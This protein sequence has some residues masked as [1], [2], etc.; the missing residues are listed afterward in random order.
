MKS[1]SFDSKSFPPRL[2][3]A[4]LSVAFAC[5]TLC[6]SA[7]AG[8]TVALT[9]RYPSEG[10]HIAAVPA[11]YTFGAAE[12]G[13][14]V[15]VN[16]HAAWI[17]PD[18]GWS[19][20]VP[21]QPGRFVLHVTARAGDAVQQVDRSIVVD[22]GE[23]SPFPSG[24]TIVQPLESVALQLTAAAGSAV[25]ASSAA[26]DTIALSPDPALGAGAYS[27]R[28]IARGQA[29]TP[30]RVTY[31]VVDAAGLERTLRSA[32]TIA[33]AS[34]PVLFAGVVVGFTPDPLSGTRPYA[35]LGPTPDAATDIMLPVGTEVNVT[36]RFGDRLRLAL[37]GQPPEFVDTHQIAPLRGVRAIPP[38]RLQSLDRAEDAQATTFRLTFA[39]TRPAFHVRELGGASGTIRVFGVGS[40]T[41]YADYPF[42]LR[43]HAFWGYRASWHGSTLVVVF[44]KPPAFAPPPHKALDGLRVVIDPGHSPDAGAIG[45]LGTEE[46]DVNLDIALRLAE[47]LRAVGARVTLTRTSNAAVLLY[48]RPALAER[49]GA[50]V[51][52][53]VHNNANPDGVDPSG[54]HGYEVY[55]FQPHSAALAQAI[56]AA[57]QRDVDI[58]DNG[59]H[60]GDFALVRTTDVPAVLTESAYVTWPWEEMR[61]RDPA[62]RARLAGAMADGM[63]RW[64]ERMRRLETDM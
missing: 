37:P 21:M 26:F 28:A 17:A 16:G 30:D 39:G 10:A 36:G 33:V 4:A 49:L 1:P 24:P 59:L 40:D 47:R 8:T 11:S 42:R 7:R 15:T 41:R 45:P 54:A 46:R 62:F 22:S 19:A 52:I 29:T 23:P 50:D 61:L 51:L 63:E 14:V 3:L 12:P 44:R 6:A 48:A 18:G 20:F 13:A 5:G 55:Y 56:H 9:V 64:A 43:Q 27:A 35:M 53:S 2:F 38:A 57:Y 58:H 60:H 25:T 32:S 31:S 34:A